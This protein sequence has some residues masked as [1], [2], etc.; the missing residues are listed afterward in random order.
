MQRDKHKSEFLV[1]TLMQ[2]NFDLK[3]KQKKTSKG[4]ISSFPQKCTKSSKFLVGALKKLFS[5]E[6]ITF[7][8]H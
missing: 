2:I 5:Y 3:Q 4:F 1:P 7:F 6:F 8:P